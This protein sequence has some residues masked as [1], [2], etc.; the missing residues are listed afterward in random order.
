MYNDEP[1]MVECF[2][3]GLASYTV[4]AVSSSPIASLNTTME[5]LP[6]KQSEP[7]CDGVGQTFVSHATTWFKTS[8]CISFVWS[9]IHYIPARVL[10]KS[11][12]SFVVDSALSSTASATPGFVLWVA[13]CT[14]VLE[15][16]PRL[17]YKP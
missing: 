4:F 9:T 13:I 8:F 2:C 12:S 16:A 1:T 10:Q 3:G 15:D 5:K 17:Q 14:K 6:E 7:C 11:Y